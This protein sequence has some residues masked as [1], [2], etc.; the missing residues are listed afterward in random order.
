MVSLCLCEQQKKNLAGQMHLDQLPAELLLS[1]CES[2]LDDYD[3]ILLA[4]TNHSILSAVCPYAIESGEF[5]ATNWLDVG[6]NMRARKRTRREDDVAPSLLEEKMSPFRVGQPT[7]VR[8]SSPAQIRHFARLRDV[9][10]EL[11]EDDLTEEEQ[12]QVACGDMLH[13]SDDDNQLS[14][15]TALSVWENSRV[16]LVFSHPFS[17]QLRV[18]KWFAADGCDADDCI[19]APRQPVPLAWLSQCSALTEIQLSGVALEDLPRDA[20]TWP[21]SVTKLHLAGLVAKGDDDEA[22]ILPPRLVFMKV[23]GQVDLARFEFPGSLCTLSLVD[24]DQSLAYLPPK[25]CYLELDRNTYTCSLEHVVFPETLQVLN[26]YAILPSGLAQIRL[27]SSLVWFSVKQ[28]IQG[29]LAAIHWPLASTTTTTTSLK[30]VRLTLGANCWN[31]LDLPHSLVYLGLFGQIGERLPRLPSRLEYLEVSELFK[32]GI[33]KPDSIPPSVRVIELTGWPEDARRF[34]L[35]L[36][37]T[38]ERLLFHTADQSLPLK[39]LQ[40]SN[41]NLFIKILDECETCNE[42]NAHCHC[43]NPI[44]HYSKA[45]HWYPLDL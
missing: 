36:P 38:V 43:S 33:E 27:P 5:R 23:R 9:C 25:L 29:D 24:F 4:R 17:D 1:I 20:F 22:I 7:D 12:M 11:D 34:Q 3:V 14:S 40:A 30:A 2:Y 16:P 28:S 26:F 8:I 21:A 39:M 42:E 37:P 32:C 13:L 35:N 10:I 31:Q 44:E 18:F 6:P 15:L 45:R 41:P 19:L